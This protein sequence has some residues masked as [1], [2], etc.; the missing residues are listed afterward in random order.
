MRDMMNQLHPVTLFAPIAAQT[1]SSTARASEII[2]LRGY[3]ACTLVLIN[4][5]NTDADVTFAVEVT[6]SDDSGM[7]GATAVADGDLVGTEALA[8]SAFGDDK[9][10][11]KIGYKGTKRYVQV[12][13][14]PTGNNS[15]DW[16]LAGVAILG[17]P[18]Q[19]ATANPPQ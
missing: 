14:T 3:N 8:A 6:E 12:T 9:E 15:G 10:C 1:N 19:A 11:R 17:H 16:F 2:D 18:D 13:V 7:S 5:T 4:G